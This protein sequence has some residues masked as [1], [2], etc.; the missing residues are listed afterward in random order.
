M[1]NH[2]EEVI[3]ILYW[4]PKAVTTGFGRKWNLGAPH[5]GRSSDALGTIH[6]VKTFLLTL[7]VNKKIVP[8]VGDQICGSWVWTTLWS[9]LFAEQSSAQTLNRKIHRC[10][11]G[12]PNNF[13]MLIQ[14]QYD[15]F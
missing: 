12:S 15:T 11:R 6:K 2:S 13:F 4:M 14:Y 1:T 8:G 10:D 7:K 5:Y 9:S 3:L